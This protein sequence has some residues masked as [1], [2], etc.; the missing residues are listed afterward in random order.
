MQPVRPGVG[1]RAR[2]SPDWWR[3]QESREVKVIHE[4]R[5]VVGDLTGQAEGHA[6][7]R[8]GG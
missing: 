5:N 8:E 4:R 3:E 7:R 1:A 2:A 6:R